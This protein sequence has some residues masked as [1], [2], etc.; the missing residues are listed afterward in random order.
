MGNEL[1]DDRDGCEVRLKG[2]GELLCGDKAFG[3]E[4]GGAH[5]WGGEVDF[6][7]LVLGC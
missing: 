6:L 3:S 5:V 4:G 2:G 1:V 7:R